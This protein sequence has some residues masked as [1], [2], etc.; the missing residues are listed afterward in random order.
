MAQ[1]AVIVYIGN[2]GVEV[3]EIQELI[4]GDVAE[5]NWVGTINGQA[6]PVKLRFNDADPDEED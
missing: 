5:V 3:E 1:Q 4:D 6:V 2:T